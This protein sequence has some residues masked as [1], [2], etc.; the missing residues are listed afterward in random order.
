MQS[1]EEEEPQKKGFLRENL[2]QVW[3]VVKS[4]Y[5]TDVPSYGNSFFF[6]IG[7]YL[8]EIFGIIAVTGMIMAIFGPFWAGLTPIGNFILS[9]HV[10]AAEAFVTL[11]F[12]HLVV[13]LFTSMYRRKKLVWMLGGIML[14]LVLL[15]FAFGVGITGDYVAQF[16]AKAGAD[17]W[18]GMGLGY[19]V[20]PLNIGAVYG[21][22]IAIVPFLLIGLIFTHYLLVKKD[23]LGKP[24]RNDIPYS[25]TKA[26]HGKMYVRMAYVFAIILL[27]AIFIR[28]PYSAPLTM[29][30]ISISQP[31]TF[32]ITLLNEFNFSSATA[33]YFDTIQPYT[34]STRNVYVSIPYAKYVNLT[35]GRNMENAYL[36]ESASVQNNY[37]KGAFSYFQNNGSIS[38][39]LNS[40]NPMI[41]IAGSL[42][43]MAQDGVYGPVLQGEEHSGLNYTYAI[44]FYADSGILY[45]HASSLG[46]LSEED[47]GM[48]KVGLKG[49]G[50]WQYGGYWT[51]PY[52]LLEV[53]TAGIP[54]W[55]DI[56]NGLIAT[57][58]FILFICL[59]Y[60]PL[61]RDIPDKL[62][63]YKLFWNRH[64]IPELKK[65][66]ED[67]EA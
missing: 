65:K 18:N 11:I 17:L 4:M 37:L 67:E 34:F 48:P 63:L 54:W 60:I 32:A 30:N 20:N 62:K 52:D 35:N 45:T 8:M 10:W 25:M 26:N 16:N 51:A 41:A 61:L 1:E 39:A 28:A 2:S 7:I 55:N 24:Y 58:S 14:F 6:T 19:W 36:S 56:E 64:T 13:N 29:H 42:V 31:D 22:H 27:F 40:S 43:R 12:L 66:K 53:A 50:I 21:W 23:G 44:R 57:I 5:I 15:E 38:G 59:P 33:T 9:I 3:S 46:G 47:L 49:T